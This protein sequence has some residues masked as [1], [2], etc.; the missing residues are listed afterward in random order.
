MNKTDPIDP[1]IN[2]WITIMVAVPTPQTKPATAPLSTSY[3]HLDSFH[4]L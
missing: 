4:I 1:G 2:T 3:S